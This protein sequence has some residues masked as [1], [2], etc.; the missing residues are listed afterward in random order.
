MSAERIRQIEAQAMKKMRALIPAPLAESGLTQQTPPSG[1]VLFG[2]SSSM[3]PQ[4][5]LGRAV[6]AKPILPPFCPR[7]TPIVASTLLSRFQQH[8]QSCA[9]TSAPC[10]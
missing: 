4:L 8:V 6:D 10:P 1:G 9:N 2:G 5:R 7:Q 3:C